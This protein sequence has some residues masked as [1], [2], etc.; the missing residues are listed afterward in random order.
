MGITDILQSFADLPI[1][2]VIRLWYD[3]G[4]FQTQKHPEL[5]FGR[6]LGDR[7]STDITN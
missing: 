1:A 5:Y 4:G 3:P 2:S 7:N 6:V